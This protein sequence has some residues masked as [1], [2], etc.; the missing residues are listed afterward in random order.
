MFSL[1]L[2]PRRHW[3]PP[4][5]TEVD[6]Y[7]KRE[8]PALD[9]FAYLHLGTGNWIVAEW[10]SRDSGLVCEVLTLGAYPT[11]RSRGQALE[12]RQKLLAPAGRKEAFQSL[13]AHERADVARVA[14]A[15]ERKKDL[16]AKI[17]RDSRPGPG[18][19]AFMA[20]PT[21]LLGAVQ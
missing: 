1:R 14:A 20:I 16:L 15:E 12:L 3:V 18:A 21:H 19:R 7:L 11:L 6:G 10:L 9:L 4:A 2:N 13:E 17:V 5:P 8:F